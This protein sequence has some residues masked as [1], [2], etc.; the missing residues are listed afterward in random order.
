MPPLSSRLM[1]MSKFSSDS[2]RH[3]AG[4]CGSNDAVKASKYISSN[5]AP[6]IWCI[7]LA[8]L[9]LALASLSCA[10]LP[11]SSCPPS[12]PADHI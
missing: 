11:S 7:R 9:T 12:G 2:G 5:S 1:A 3:V 10:F 8:W 6:S 4:V